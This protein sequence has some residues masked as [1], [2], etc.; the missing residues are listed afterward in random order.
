MMILVT[1]EKY[2]RQVRQEY[3]RRTGHQMP[4]GSLYVTL[5]RM[6]QQGYLKSRV[7]DPVPE[8][9][10]NRRK[11]YWV[12]GLGERALAAYESRALQLRGGYANA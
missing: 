12:T 7:G 10:G 6:T 5:D 3:E 8:R 4:Y 11:F 1:G 9:G 2:G